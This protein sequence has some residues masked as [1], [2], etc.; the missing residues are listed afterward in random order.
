MDLALIKLEILS[1]RLCRLKRNVER[2]FA[3]AKISLL[4]SLKIN[5]LELIDF[6]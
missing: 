2:V 4:F 3:L 1:I 6:G 5:A